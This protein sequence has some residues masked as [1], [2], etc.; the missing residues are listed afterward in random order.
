MKIDRLMGIVLYLL[1]RGSASASE[2]AARFEVSKRTVQ[3]DMD[4][5]DM[6]GIPIVASYG[7]D[8]GYSLME[9]FTLDRRLL[10]VKDLQQLS[11]ALAALDSA[12]GGDAGAKTL[13]SAGIHAPR[14]RVM[15]NLSSARE[16]PGTDALIAQLEA[17]VEAG[18]VLRIAYE[19]ADRMQTNRE[20]EP[21]ALVYE[22]YAWYLLAYCRMREDYRQFKLDRIISC[23]GIGEFFDPGGY[24]AILPQ[25][26]LGSPDNRRSFRLRLLCRAPARTAILEY[27]R[28][29]IISE[30]GNGDFL[31]EMHVI[32]SE[33]MWF[34]LLM[35]FG[36][37][38]EVLE[39]EVLRQRLRQ[40]SGEIHSLYGE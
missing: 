30:M 19:D 34:S 25:A 12:K 35:G 22:Y 1:S 29:E 18:E 2:L 16:K 8:G 17:A 4:A 37:E 15:V 7:V 24:E 28:G 9:G 21:I 23:R 11:T 20:V 31:Y 39:P 5:L 36:S 32:E 13:L 40:V 6:A 10:K 33:R 3:R 26:Q 38:V 27:L 14:P